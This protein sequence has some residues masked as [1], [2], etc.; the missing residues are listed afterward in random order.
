MNCHFFLRLL[1]SATLIVGAGAHHF[2]VFSQDSS[3]ISVSANVKI[4]ND[5]S[6]STVN[7]LPKNSPMFSGF[8]CGDA[9]KIQAF[10][11]SS[12]FVNGIYIIDS[13]GYVDLP[14]IGLLKVINLTPRQLEQTLADRYIRFLPRLT[15]SIR[16]MIRVSLLGGFQKPGLY[17]I[18]PR[19][20]L[21][22][23]IEKAGGTVRDDGIS[24]IR[25]E[26]DSTVISK[27][28]AGYFQSGQSLYSIGFKSGDRLL[29]TAKPREQG[30][31]SFR[32]NILPVLSILVTTMTAA[33]TSYFYYETSKR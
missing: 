23:T 22:G 18:D 8:H 25:W 29:V 1:F 12:G 3:N 2:P 6:G 30:W 24:K 9:I 21:W 31:D 26:R 20:S 7:L 11:D 33:A 28:V 13:D 14:L 16:P 27:N 19:E 17:W 32:N 10:P 15:I 5:R 4:E